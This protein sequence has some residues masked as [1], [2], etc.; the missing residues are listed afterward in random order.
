MSLKEFVAVVDRTY[1]FSSCEGCEANC[2]DG[3]KGS[4]YSQI[5]L[6]EFEL[7]SKNFPIAFLLGEENLLTPV[8]LLSSGVEHCKYNKEYKCT[9]Y[10]HRPAV[11]RYY[12]LSPHIFNKTFIDLSCPAVSQ[13]NND[14]V[15]VLNGEV[16]KKYHHPNLDNYQ[17]KFLATYYEFESYNK[18]ENIELLVT[19]NDKSFYRFKED[20]S[21]KYIDIHL[22]SMVHFDKYYKN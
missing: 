7:V 19:I 15:I 2:C 18:L 16:Q 14:E 22:R 6:D 20:F 3:K 13:N 17:D 11:C 9:I 4:I 1:N 8:V 12:P 21:N 5:L 10:E